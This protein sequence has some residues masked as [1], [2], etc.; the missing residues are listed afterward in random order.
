MAE[1]NSTTSHL[2]SEAMTTSEDTQSTLG[3]TATPAWSKNYFHTLPVVIG[4]IGT[5]GNALILY[6]MVV[7]KQHKKQL[8]IFNQNVLDLYT[9]ISLII[10]NSV[11]LSINSLNGSRHGYWLCTL[12]ISDTFVWIG[13]TGSVM[14]LAIIT[15]ERYLKICTK[16][17]VSNRMIYSAVA[18]AWIGSAVHWITAVFSTTVVINGACFVYILFR[19]ESA[20]LF[21]TICNVLSFYV[22]IIC[23]FIFCYGRILIV[24]RRQAKVM[25]SHNVAGSG[26]IQTQSNQIQTNVI[27]TMIVVSAFYVI[28]WFPSCV[29]MLLYHF[30]FKS[31]TTTLTIAYS[32]SILCN[33]LYMCINPFIYAIKFDPVKE[34]LIRMIP[35]KK[36]TEQASESTGNTGIRVAAFRN[37]V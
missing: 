37:T 32:V 7:S 26:T 22:I 31:I 28:T 14:N 3:N 18:F 11:K 29:V 30:L 5:A 21:F 34:V 19:G 15:I 27:K 35:C 4:V 20:K 23:I 9:C 10:S 33:F 8:L 36:T 12:F 17:Q 2:S 25:A 1:E 6:A 13:N 16:K 24:I